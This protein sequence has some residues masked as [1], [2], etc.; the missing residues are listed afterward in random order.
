ME[1]KSGTKYV[2]L[3]FLDALTI[4]F[5]ALK[6]C[7]V[8]SWSWVWVLSPLWITAVL[9]IVIAVIA[10]IVVAVFKER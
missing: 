3:G 7:G 9:I 8:I 6:L 5:I 1:N 2:G 10:V 4:L